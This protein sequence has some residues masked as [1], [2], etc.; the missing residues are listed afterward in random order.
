MN[1][2][3]G[4]LSVGTESGARFPVERVLEYSL[5]DTATKTCTIDADIFFFNNT[6]SPQRLR[7]MH[8]GSMVG[9]NTT[10]EAWG[11]GGPSGWSRELAERIISLHDG[12]EP[13]TR[14]CEGVTVGELKYQLWDEPEGRIPAIVGQRE[15][16]DVPF[17]MWEIGPFAPQQRHVVRLQMLMTPESYDR[18]IGD[19]KLIYAYGS[20]ILLEQINLETLPD[21]AGPD[22]ESYQ[23]ALDSLRADL[24]PDVFE[25]LLVS[26][27]ERP[28]EWKTTPVTNNL[29]P[30]LITNELRETTHWFV[31]DYIHAGRWKLEG[32]RLVKRRPAARP[33]NAFTL[34]I[35]AVELAHR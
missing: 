7:I 32:E 17:T 20:A 8:P 9:K 30:R 19:G 11:I 18:Q 12:A 15:G 28:G 25:W 2:M 1:R 24:V 5:I 21:Y 14:T 34:E 33:T 35:E 16:S 13:I 3:T 29:S 22:S 23:M 6:D 27:E 31:A 10:R 26:P 4:C